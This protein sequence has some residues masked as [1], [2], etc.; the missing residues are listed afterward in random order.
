MAYETLLKP[1]LAA[2]VVVR[3]LR[4]KPGHT[5]KTGGG[6]LG[7]RFENDYI[8][9]KVFDTCV[10]T[11]ERTGIMI[12]QRAILAIKA[13]D[14]STKNFVDGILGP[15]TLK[16]ANNADPVILLAAIIQQ[17]LIHYDK[18]IKNNPKLDIYR[19]GWEARAYKY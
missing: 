4:T 6:R 7:Q 8:A 14:G 5:M 18:L 15:N 12:L 19:K 9:R 13:W 2:G 17:Q 1:R 16:A 11:G 3:T 10:N